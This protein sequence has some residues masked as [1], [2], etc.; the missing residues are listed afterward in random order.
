MRSR[1]LLLALLGGLGLG[2]LASLPS[3]ADETVSADKINRL[4]E[5]MGSGSFADREKATKELDAIGV[6]ALEA[7]RKA[8]KSDDVEVKRR[9]GELLKK[10]EKQAESAKLLAAKRVHLVY[11]E[12]PI[13]EAVADF[14]KK[15]GYTIH[16]HDP[17]GKLK[18]RKIT[19]DTGETTFW[20]AF[21]LFCEKAGL[22]E[23][24]MQEVMQEMMRIQGGGP[25]PIRKPP[26]KKLP[27]RPAPGTLPEAPPAPPAKQIELNAAAV[28]APPAPA[29]AAQ[30]APP[31][32]APPQ[33]VLRRG[34]MPR[35]PAWGSGMPGQVLLL[36][37]GKL[38]KLPTDDRSAVRI[39]ALPKAAMF[40]DAPEGEIILALE[41][42]PEPRLQWQGLQSVR[43]EKALDDQGQKLTQVTPQVPAPA[44]G[45]GAGGP[46]IA[47]PAVAIQPAIAQA[48]GG[49][50][51]GWGGGIHPTVPVQLKKGEKA[52]KALKELQGVISAK[53]LSEA[54]PMIVADNLAKAKGKTFKGKE[55]G[56]IK[57]LDVKT[58]EK[59]TTIQFEFEPTPNT[60]PEMGGGM[61]GMMGMMPGMGAGMVAPAV[62]AIRLQPAAPAPAAP[63]PPDKGKKKRG[64]AALAAA[65]PAQLVRA[66]VVAPVQVQG[67]GEIAIAIGNAP[68]FVGP[69]NGLVVQ[70]DKG[71]TLPVQ[72]GPQEFRM[73]AGPGGANVLTVTY[74]LICEPGKD[75]GPAAKVVYMGRK[76]VAV[77]VPFTLKDVPLP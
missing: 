53:M 5:Q 38:R 72:M 52:A 73:Q 22:T 48:G 55:G 24:T 11:K 3:S 17:E 13:A 56:S 6:P 23:S 33:A 49:W 47:P 59:K 18:E 25:V 64:A 28:E 37:D 60:V 51:G 45:I 2:L 46:G 10:I 71:N 69:F 20:H 57:V 29:P 63:P 4:I 65:A 1:Y 50:G 39:R 8:A 12:T 16:L 44:A 41:V 42:T 74:T 67:G 34:G 62:P 30:P 61:M 31:A 19:L 15:S 66:Q 70:D 9:A 54:T 76:H 32:A 27:P 7:L 58:E 35:M 77:D 40:G 36:K 43:I 68:M 21:E 75:Q 14:E 26:I